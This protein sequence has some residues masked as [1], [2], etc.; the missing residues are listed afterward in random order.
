MKLHHIQSRQWR[1]ITPFRCC[2][3]AHVDNEMYLSRALERLGGNAMNKDQE[4]DIGAAFLKF[5]VVTK[6]LSALMKTLVSDVSPS[7][8]T[9]RSFEVFPLCPLRFGGLL[10]LFLWPYGFLN[11]SNMW[12]WFL[13]SSLS[14]VNLVSVNGDHNLCSRS[15]YLFGSPSG[16]KSLN[17][18]YLYIAYM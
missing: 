2:F 10:L 7:L 14:C 17:I 18:I 9:K 6:E 5:A 3:P 12:R 11:R 13:W 1:P 15:R 4:P 16:I 8:Y